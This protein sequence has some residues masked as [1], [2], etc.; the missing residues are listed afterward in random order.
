MGV[1]SVHVLGIALILLGA[2]GWA[3]VISAVLPTTILQSSVPDA[4][5]TRITSVQMAVVEG[6]PRL[7]AFESGAVATATSTAF[8]VVS[9]GVACIAGALLLAG[10]LPGFRC[11]ERRTSPHRPPGG[12]V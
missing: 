1:Q 6:G 7:G 4:L 12:G 9:G 10:L 11:F 5:R 3:D 8:S 2:A